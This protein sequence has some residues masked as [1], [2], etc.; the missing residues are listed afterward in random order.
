LQLVPITA[1]ENLVCL[2]SCTTVDAITVVRVSSFWFCLIA[3]KISTLD[4]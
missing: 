1:T 3:P 4:R 2:A